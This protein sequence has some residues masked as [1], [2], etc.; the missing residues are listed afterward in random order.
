MHNQIEEC[1]QPGRRLMPARGR[2]FSEWVK[3][4]KA[5]RPAGQAYCYT[6]T[7]SHGAG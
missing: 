6:A 4:I 3:G 2:D 5:A 7:A 1:L